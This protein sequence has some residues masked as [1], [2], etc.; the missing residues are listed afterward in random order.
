MNVKLSEIIDAIEFTDN[1]SHYF[2][3]KTTGEVVLINDMTMSSQEQETAYDTLDEHRFFRLPEQREL[4]GYHTM[5]AFIETLPAPARDR[6][7]ST[8]VSR[9]AFRR[10]KYE[11]HRLGV[12]E[13]WYDYEEAVHRK[14]AIEWCKGNGIEYED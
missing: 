10:F 14:K 13:S 4:N 5:E 9:G 12:E 1:Y 8:I 2:L 3:D 7:A 11:I 6:L